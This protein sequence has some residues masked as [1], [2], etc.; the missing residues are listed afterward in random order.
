MR[1]GLVGLAAAILLTRVTVVA[2]S[3]LLGTSLDQNNQGAYLG[4]EESVGPP[5]FLLQPFSLNATVAV[6]S[7]DLVLSGPI[8]VGGSTP[9]RS[10]L[11]QITNAVG[12]GATSANVLAQGSGTFPSGTTPEIVS[13]ALSGILSPGGYYLVLSSS[14]GAG[15]WSQAVGVV[16]SSV[17]AVGAPASF[18]FNAGANIT[19]PPGSGWGE[20][21]EPTTRFTFQLVGNTSL[22]VLIDIK[23]G[24]D[25]NTFNLSSSGV[26]PVAI[27]STADFDA[28]AVEPE[29]VSLAGASVKLV[30]KGVR[31]LC[32]FEDV[33][34]DNLTDLI[35]Q[36]NTAQFMVEEGSSTAVLEAMTVD[37][38]SIRGQDHVRIVPDQ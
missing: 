7:I 32:H 14:T 28:T 20:F 29:S 11:V 18:A 13:V 33:N 15:A 36:V 35:C 4:G 27:L 34:A 12:P 30:G 19:F 1:K 3:V 2:Y 21:S 38:V 25:E 24:S 31:Y 23:P 22:P 37:G 5:Q 26:I 16:P 17:G 6:S 8:P 10:F 9:P